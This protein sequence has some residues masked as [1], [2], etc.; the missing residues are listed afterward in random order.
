[1]DGVINK[2]KGIVEEERTIKR[3]SRENSVNHSRD[4]DKAQRHRNLK[5][6]PI[7]KSNGKKAKK[8]EKQ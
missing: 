1:M 2:W 5:E 4:E 3:E 7:S 8:G 6:S